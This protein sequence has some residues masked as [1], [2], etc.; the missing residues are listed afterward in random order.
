M[1]KFRWPALNLSRVTFQKREGLKNTQ[2]IPHCA[3]FVFPTIYRTMYTVA[4]LLTQ[5]CILINRHKGQYRI[6]Y[7]KESMCTLFEYDNYLHVCTVHQ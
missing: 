2:I 4:H 5:Q 6:Q 3:V 1:P 7:W